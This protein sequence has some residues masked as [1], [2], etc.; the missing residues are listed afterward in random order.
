MS[1]ALELL[2]DP[3]LDVLFSGDSAFEELPNV[4]RRLCGDGAPQ[5]VL[6]H[7]IRYD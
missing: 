1:V 4:M 6:C 5:G 3:A 7:R 2:R